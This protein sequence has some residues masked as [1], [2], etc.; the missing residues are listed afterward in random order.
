MTA[1]EIVLKTKGLRNLEYEKVLDLFLERYHNTRLQ[2]VI[3]EFGGEYEDFLQ[4][5]EI[6]R[7]QYPITKDQHDDWWKYLY[8][9]LKTRFRYSQKDTE[10][11]IFYF[12]IN[13][14]TKII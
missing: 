13:C 1:E 12:N 10:N 5:Y 3:N 9:L 8:K 4:K 11:Y 6:F 2:N 14:M 7:E